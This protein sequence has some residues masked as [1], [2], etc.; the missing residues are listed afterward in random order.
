MPEPYDLLF[1][2][3]DVLDPGGGH[4]GR[5]DVAVRDGRIAEVGAALPREA[6]TVVHAGG[7]LVTPGL[8]DPH[9]HVQPGGG[10][11]G[12]D[13]DPIAWYSEVTR[14]V[15]QGPDRPADLRGGR[16]RW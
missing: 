10:Y 3:G 12:V 1:V 13:P 11:R 15:Q 14:D 4:C 7:R 16:G 5:L 9:T 6:G 8:V 2:G